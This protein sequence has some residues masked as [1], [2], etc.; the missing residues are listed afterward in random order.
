ML[1]K[2]DSLVYDQRTQKNKRKKIIFNFSL[3]LP[4]VKVPDFFELNQ[5]VRAKNV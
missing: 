3:G 2:F 4:G 5:K 1:S